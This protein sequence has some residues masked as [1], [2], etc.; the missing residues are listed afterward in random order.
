MRK[1]NEE[2]EKITAKGPWKLGIFSD[3]NTSEVDG[4]LGRLSIALEKFKVCSTSDKNGLG[5]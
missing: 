3:V 1:I 5:G 4:C 2:L